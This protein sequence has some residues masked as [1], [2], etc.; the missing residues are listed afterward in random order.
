[1]AFYWKLLIFCLYIRE[2]KEWHT[3]FQFDCLSVDFCGWWVYSCYYMAPYTYNIHIY[4]YVIY[5][6]TYE[7]R[8]EKVIEWPDNNSSAIFAGWSNWNNHDNTNC[9]WW[10]E[11]VSRYIGPFSISYPI[12]FEL[13][14]L[15]S[16]L[17]F[18]M[19]ALCRVCF[20]TIGV[21]M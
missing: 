7:W 3:A 12:F 19:I 20:S 21:Y 14:E 16:F 17:Y 2:K 10:S 8:E 11:W 9:D 4:V 1:M 13:N 6:Y 18:L 5:M 15:S